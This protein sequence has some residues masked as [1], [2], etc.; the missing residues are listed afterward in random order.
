MCCHLVNGLERTNPWRHC[1]ALFLISKNVVP[2]VSSF[3]DDGDDSDDD[4]ECDDA[5]E[6]T[7]DLESEEEEAEV[8]EA[9]TKKKVSFKT[10]VEELGK[11]KPLPAMDPEQFKVLLLVSI[12][13]YY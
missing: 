7:S 11:K 1:C 10:T 12:L 6:R 5:M 2:T 4:D 3:T 13:V 9:K 8:E